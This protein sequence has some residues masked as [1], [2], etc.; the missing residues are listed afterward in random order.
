MA[1]LLPQLVSLLSIGVDEMV[2][3]EWRD[4]VESDQRTALNQLIPGSGNVM[5][6]PA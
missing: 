5:P 4:S 3:V 2:L 6:E 1:R